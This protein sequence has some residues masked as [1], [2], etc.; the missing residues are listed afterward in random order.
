MVALK[1]TLGSFLPN[2]NTKTVAENWVSKQSFFEISKLSNKTWK[3]LLRSSHFWFLVFGHFW[4]RSWEN[5]NILFNLCSHFARQDW[6]DRKKLKGIY[7]IKVTKMPRT[8]RR[9]NGM[10]ETVIK[11]NMQLKIA[12]I[13]VFNV[14]WLLKELSLKAIFLDVSV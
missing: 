6:Q 12:N 8:K 3:F 10:N 4:G 14:I 1:F 2:Q 11:L 13:S 7:V 5:V 9:K